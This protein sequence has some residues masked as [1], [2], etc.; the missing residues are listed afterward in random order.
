MMTQIISMGPGFQP[1]SVCAQNPDCFHN[2]RLLAEEE[3]EA[4]GGSLGELA[5]EQGTSTTCQESLCGHREKA[6]AKAAAVLDPAQ[7]PATAFSSGDLPPLRGTW[8][9]CDRPQGPNGVGFGLVLKEG[10]APPMPWR[11]PA[12]WRGGGPRRV[13]HRLPV[14]W[15]QCRGQ[16]CHTSL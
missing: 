8:L 5:Q 13:G 7:D 1:T 6:A 12:V 3:T 16:L 15:P 2:I 11:P 4:W 14:T 9:C 10:S